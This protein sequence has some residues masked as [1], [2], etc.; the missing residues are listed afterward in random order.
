MKK[1]F[2]DLIKTAVLEDYPV[3]EDQI[4]IH[5][6]G[7]YAYQDKDG[8][9]IEESLAIVK[10]GSKR[11]MFTRVIR[12]HHRQILSDVVYRST[13]GKENSIYQA[14]LFIAAPKSKNI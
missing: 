9:G 5:S 13:L 10:I 14:G 1:K 8:T 11:E 6:F 2:E 4:E 7:G 12:T 3:S